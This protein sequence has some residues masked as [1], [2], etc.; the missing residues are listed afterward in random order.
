MRASILGAGAPADVAARFMATHD[1]SLEA[2]LNTFFESGGEGGLPAVAPAAAPAPAPPPFGARLPSAR[3][4][5]PEAAADAP[6]AAAPGPP[7]EDRSLGGV[8]TIIGNA[9]PAA[10]PPP[11]SR[12]T[13]FGGAGRKLGGASELGAEAAAAGGAPEPEPE[14]IE[15]QLTF[16]ADGFVRSPHCAR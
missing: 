4:P 15:V 12:P 6:A 11:G 7:K 13:V 5:E 2:A 10:G 14:P 1:G 3:P 9:K 16:W 8:D